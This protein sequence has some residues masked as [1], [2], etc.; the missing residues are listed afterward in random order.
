MSTDSSYANTLPTRTLVL[1]CLAAGLGVLFWV[2]GRWDVV[3]VTLITFVTDGG[4]AILVF[5]AAGGYGDLIVRP[6]LG[7]DC[8][9]GLRVATAC[10]V[11]LWAF[12]TLML[13]GGSLFVGLL[14]GWVWW[15][16]IGLGLI[17]A[18]SRGRAFFES[19]AIPREVQGRSLIWVLLA[20]SLAVWI[21]GA[22]RPPLYVGVGA[23]EYDV[24]GYHMQV[25]AEYFQ[26]NHIAPLEHNVYS[27]FPMGV[28]MLYLL[29]MCLRGG[30]YEGMYAAKL[31][32]GLFA[33][34]A[35][36]AMMSS[37][38]TSEVRRWASGVLLATTPFV[39]Y[40][41][42]LGMVELAG[43]FYLTLALLWLRRW[44]RD[45][46]AGSAACVGIAIGGACATKYLSVGFVA[47]PVTLM[48]VL[49]SLA[50]PRRV[51][52]VIVAVVVAAVLFA[53]WLIRNDAT[54]GNPVFPL[55]VGMF[56]SGDH[57][58]DSDEQSPEADAR[59]ALL[60]QRWA[61]GHGP[62][63]RPPV[64]A[65][66]GW[67]S[68][69]QS[70]RLKMFY[71]NFLSLDKFGPMAL[72]L[73]G[74]GLCMLVSIK[75]K[76]D[77]WEWAVLGVIVVQL[78]VWTWGTHEMP[79]RFLV[80]VIVPIVL[81]AGWALERIYQLKV[82]PF[83][84][85]TDPSGKPWGVV[86]AGVLLILAAGTNA[87]VS[88]YASLA[89]RDGLANV[90]KLTPTNGFPIRD[91][92]ASWLAGRGLTDED[93]P[94]LIGEAKAL[95]FPPATVY[96]TTFDIHPLAKMIDAGMSAE[97]V[98]AELQA[99]GIT[100]IYIDW[101]EVIRLSLTYGYSPSLA[102][103]VL[104]LLPEGYRLYGRQRLDE[105]LSDQPRLAILEQMKSLGLVELSMPISAPERSAEPAADPA[106]EP[107]AD[108]AP[109][110]TAETDAADGTETPPPAPAG[111][112]G[113]RPAK[114]VIQLR[115][116]YSVPSPARPEGG[117]QESP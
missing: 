82:S 101:A 97:E 17:V 61:D 62:D 60:E 106:A 26:A 95:Y 111:D 38:R 69:T 36:L 90:M 50:K 96:A 11:G 71:R 105:A 58:Y 116:L 107:Q 68:P 51:G 22:T 66:A 117:E 10:G 80:P 37:F 78:A 44:M 56:G 47:L 29:G 98:L 5:I 48:M 9:A 64:P 75:G 85:N 16:V 89:T 99:D 3:V 32:H 63:K 34:L 109:S 41:S 113:D 28:E 46:S 88:V 73:A 42:W 83:S 14:T 53:P 12:G 65:P 93:K 6:L 19:R 1:M 23:D 55:A 15:P 76:T 104:A 67:R 59:T 54:V 4:L 40:L 20:A 57:W 31:M 52:H 86:V 102:G 100:H 112:E 2:S 72:V 115:V 79:P 8:P 81:L 49:L 35:V 24:A 25:P 114:P 84:R 92:A 87:L 70:S 39:L 94:M 43:I 77:P 91:V 110:E 13:T 30:V 45:G 74:V 7:K 18:A 21:A 108:D 27:Y 103:D 33:A